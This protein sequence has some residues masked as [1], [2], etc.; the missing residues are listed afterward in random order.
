MLKKALLKNPK[1][2]TTKRGRRTMLPSEIDAKV[3][4]MVCSM[5]GAG[6]V[7]NFHTLIGL[8]TGIVIANDRTLLNEY[9][10]T[11][12]F[13]VGWCQSIFKRL[14]FVR[15]KATTAKPEIAPGLIDEIGF[16]F[17]KEINDLVGWFNIPKDSIINIDQTP[18]PY[19]LVSSYTMEEKVKQC[20]PISGT[21]DYRQITGTFG[22]TL[23]GEF[24]PIQLIYKGKTPRCQPN[25]I[26]PEEFHVTDGKPLG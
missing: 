24:L 7:T 15:R 14:N 4:A 21:T 2:S 19:V 16:S 22:V 17:F 1:Q 10:G 9:G 13:S 12:E 8:A 18:L 6:A 11:A 26:F 20:V 25:Y 23:S 5:R 3:L